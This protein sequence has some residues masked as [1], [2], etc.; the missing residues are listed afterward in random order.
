MAQTK[1]LYKKIKDLED[2]L[3]YTEAMLEEIYEAQQA[4]FPIFVDLV[5][6]ISKMYE[7]MDI[8]DREIKKRMT[9]LRE[10]FLETDNLID[11]Y[12]LDDEY[13]GGEH[14]IAYT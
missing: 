14:N 1:D 8:R 4:L 11:K 5:Q 10:T 12:Y 3:H 6:L 2:K 13:G 9:R 7:E